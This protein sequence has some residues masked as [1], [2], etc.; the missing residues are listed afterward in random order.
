[1]ETKTNPLSVNAR[2][3]TW[4]SDLSPV[5]QPPPWIQNTTGRSFAPGGE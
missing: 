4:T 2:G 1:M 3:L 5:C